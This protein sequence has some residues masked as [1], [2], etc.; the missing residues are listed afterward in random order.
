MHKYIFVLL[1]LVFTSCLSNY[2]PV[3][4]WHARYQHTSGK[5]YL[6][7]NHFT[8]D[9]VAVDVIEQGQKKPR[10]IFFAEIKEDMAI[11]K[12]RTD[13]D[14]RFILKKTDKGFVVSDQCYGGV[15]E[16]DGLYKYVGDYKP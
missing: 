12:N 10:N 1:L 5:F 8:D 7:L 13:P 9:A 6:L 16:I 2:A 15:S 14:C 3:D 11:F 4:P